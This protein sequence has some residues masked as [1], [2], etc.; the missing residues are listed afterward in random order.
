MTMVDLLLVYK[1]D[2][3]FPFSVVAAVLGIVVITLVFM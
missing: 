3:T 1:Y 2:G